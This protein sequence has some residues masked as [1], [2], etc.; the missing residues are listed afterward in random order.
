MEE[1]RPDN[2]AEGSTVC[3]VDLDEGNR[4]EANGGMA[5]G[6][7]CRDQIDGKYPSASG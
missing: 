1:K 6:D 2:I 4:K 7:C 5:I 3:H